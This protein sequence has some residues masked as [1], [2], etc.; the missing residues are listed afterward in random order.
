MI[1]Q[2]RAHVERFAARILEQGRRRV[3]K[4]PFIQ[5]IGPTECGA[6][7]LA[8]T[9]GYHGSAVRVEELIETLG[10][11]RDGVTARALVDAARRYD[12]IGRG[13]KIDVEDFPYLEPGTILHWEF[14]HFVVLEKMGRAEVVILDPADGRR[15]IPMDRFR[16]SFTGVALLFERGDLFK[17]RARTG[18]QLWRYLAAM[19]SHRSVWAHVLVAGL[20]MQAFALALP[21]MTTAVVDR[22]VP[23]GEHDTF[24]VLVAGLAGLAV[25]QVLITTV[26]SHL[27]L[28]VRT[29]FD[30]QMSTGF[31][32]HLL[33]LPYAFFMR[34]SSGDLLRRLDS[35]N[36]IRETLTTSVLGALIDGLLV[37]VY[38]VLL[39][40]LDA[41]IGFLA[42]GLGALQLV[43][44]RMA[45]GRQTEMAAEGLRV[46]ANLTGV[47]IELL[48]AIQTIKVSAA[49]SQ[50]L[51]KWGNAYTD[52]LNNALKQLRFRI[53][54]QAASQIVDLL[55]PIVVLA[56]G[57]LKVLSGQLSLGTMLGLNM[58]AMGFLR[59]FLNLIN[60]AAELRL[61][62]TYL[63]RLEDVFNQPGETQQ[64]RPLRT[65]ALTGQAGLDRVSF[66]YSESGPLVVEDISIDLAAGEFVALV[67][68]SGSGKST[69]ASLF[70]G[71][72]PPSGG[73]VLY[74]GVDLADLDVRSVRG[75]VGTVL[76]N[77]Y[78]LAG[79]I[80]ENICFGHH[81]VSWDEMVRAARMVD[82]HEE[83]TRMPMGYETP[84]GEG[85]SSLSG[86]QR[87]RV[88]I[89]RALVREPVLLVLDEATSSLDAIT[90]QRI[91][92]R[93]DALSCTRLVIAHRLSTVVHADRILVMEGGHIVEAGTHAELLR[94]QG[95]YA[96]LVA[97]QLRDANPPTDLTAWLSQR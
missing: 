70:L 76:Q 25:F 8:M 45:I 67:G 58:M 20:L 1:G 50:A 22:I 7:C 92:E 9:L 31:L 24:L 53:A 66:R 18:S 10:S 82:L 94:Q 40:L 52:S 3:L 29:L 96:R 72:Y 85:G 84:V 97:A 81:D 54:F 74:D 26:R 41:T 49:E 64:D 33:D 59:P 14:N 39:L 57:T 78:L 23:R 6:A 43:L 89:A 5:Q 16:K 34:R 62:G 77:T 11:S 4:V 12:L 2:A 71:L 46:H 83:I 93:L 55:S 63:E 90:E 51:D 17:P 60:A 30:A 86:G 36:E 65:L 37:V 38:V 27:M 68:A 91:H 13:V 21:A 69:L 28:R 47:E 88:A 35:N 19:A 56:A 80:R 48:K 95:V 15:V 44:Y 75:Q 87:Q 61:V 32:A 79:T 73:R 42:L